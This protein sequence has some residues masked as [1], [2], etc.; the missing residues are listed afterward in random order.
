VRPQRWLQRVRSVRARRLR[1]GALGTAGVQQALA[2]SAEGNIGGRSAASQLN[3]TCL[4]RG[5]CRTSNTSGPQ[6]L[7]LGSGNQRLSC[8]AEEPGARGDS[9]FTPSDCPV[10]GFTPL[11]AVAMTMNCER[12]VA[13]PVDSPDYSTCAR[14]RACSATAALAHGGGGGGCAAAVWRLGMRCVRLC[15][16]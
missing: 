10:C 16:A 11:E 13:D 14:R 3:P 9:R 12:M 5:D 7:S 8:A 2:V 6:C 15:L 1:A 4:L